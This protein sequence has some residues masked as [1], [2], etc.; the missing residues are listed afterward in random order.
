MALETSM[1]I[2][3]KWLKIRT[4]LDKSGRLVT[5]ATST[6]YY[7]CTHLGIFTSNVEYLQKLIVSEQMIDYY[8]LSRFLTELEHIDNA[9]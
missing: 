8:C 1:G 4:V 7:Y 5:I 2:R 6:V 9:H 3:D